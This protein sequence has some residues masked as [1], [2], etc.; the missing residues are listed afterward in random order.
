MMRSRGVLATF[1]VA[2][3][4]LALARRPG[5]PSRLMILEV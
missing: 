3:P 1:F 5:S 2:T 4:A